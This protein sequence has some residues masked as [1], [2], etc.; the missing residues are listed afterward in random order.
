VPPHLAH[1][2]GAESPLDGVGGDAIARLNTPPVARD[3]ARKKIERRG[4]QK[5]AGSLHRR[6]ERRDLFPQRYL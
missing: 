3:L 6:Q 2:A 1:A 5:V 4:G